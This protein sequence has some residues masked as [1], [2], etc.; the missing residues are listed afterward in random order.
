[1]VL[2]ATS[3]AAAVLLLSIRRG[4]Q[5]LW[6]W[7]L[8]LTLALLAAAPN[9][10]L[11]PIAASMLCLAVLMVLLFRVSLQLRL[12]YPS[13]SACCSH[14]GSNLDEWFFL[15]PLAIA[16]L[17]AGTLIQTLRLGG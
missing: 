5:S 13:A 15:G 8:V 12:R 10:L 7:V 3:L 11:A 9:T 14:F 6:P 2:K 16:M 1:M 17:L 4:G